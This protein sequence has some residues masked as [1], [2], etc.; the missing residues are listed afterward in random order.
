MTQV[1][2]FL[3]YT[4]TLACHPG[5]TVLVESTGLHS[6]KKG[7]ESNIFNLV[8]IRVSHCLGKGLLRSSHLLPLLHSGQLFGTS[9][10]ASPALALPHLGSSAHQ[11]QGTRPPPLPGLQLG[12]CQARL[13]LRS[14]PIRCRVHHPHAHFQRL[15]WDSHQVCET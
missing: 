9:R 15:N 10:D 14:H 7:A 4:I 3:L 13:H 12:A 11:P 2:I 1:T 6:G 8:L 5:L